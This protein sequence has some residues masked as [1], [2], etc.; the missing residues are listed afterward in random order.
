MKS[1]DSEDVA[2][3]RE[4]SSESLFCLL[5]NQADRR[6]ALTDIQRNA[7]LNN[8]KN[9][10]ILPMCVADTKEMISCSG[11]KNCLTV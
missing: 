8:G 5:S 11:M 4:P 2:L 6:C 10:L 7:I 9:M 3:K 1:R